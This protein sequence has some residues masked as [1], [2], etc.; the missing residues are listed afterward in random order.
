MLLWLVISVHHCRE[1]WQ[2]L[3]VAFCIYFILRGGKHYVG[4]KTFV[5]WADTAK[6]SFIEFLYR[7]GMF[8]AGCVQTGLGVGSISLASR[9][10]SPATS[11]SLY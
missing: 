5:S 3:R 1:I 10:F 4:R 11:W 7:L 9:E 8:Y 2:A 6:Y